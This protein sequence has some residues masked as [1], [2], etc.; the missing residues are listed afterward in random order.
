MRFLTMTWLGAVCAM[1][2]PFAGAAPA[3]DALG[4][5]AAFAVRANEVGHHAA[6]VEYLA[7][8]AVLFRPE[9]VR[10]QEWLAANE[11]AA[12]QLEWSP[13]AAAA[14]CNGRLAVTSGAWRYSNDAGGEPVAGHYLSVW[15]LMD[16]GRWLVALDH[17]ID[18]AGAVQPGDLLATTFARF[19]PPPAADAGCGKRRRGV[20]PEAAEREL[21]ER[22]R[23]EGLP[24]ALQRA[25]AD[26]ALAYR[27]DLP[28]VPL[29]EADLRGD[30][31][32]PSGSEAQTVGVIADAEADLAVTHG[33]L[34]AAD[35]SARALYVR[36]WQHAREGWR[37]AVD[38]QTPLPL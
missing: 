1:S 37:V 36:V 32:F 2:A 12:G 21:N 31:R 18:H 20:E 4:A 25:A 35:G 9:A 19:W 8:E 22:V 3:D 17:G 34:R 10:G 27:D 13:S 28:P 29:A 23:R 38:L 6:F 16:D 11:P 33:V 15:R 30:G 26:G 24:A 5:D 14:A 7:A